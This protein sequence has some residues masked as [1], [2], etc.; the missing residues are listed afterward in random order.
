MHKGGEGLHFKQWLETPARVGQGTL[1]G[2]PN[3][4]AL[5]EGK[6]S[7]GKLSHQPRGWGAG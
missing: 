5:G 7:K 3:K 1:N 2:S 4:T 6:F